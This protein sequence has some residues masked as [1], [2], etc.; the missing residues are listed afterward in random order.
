MIVLELALELAQPFL[1]PFLP[2]PRTKVLFSPS[3]DSLHFPSDFVE[4]S[5]LTLALLLVHN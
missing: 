4:A 3:A 2:K 1:S 5:M